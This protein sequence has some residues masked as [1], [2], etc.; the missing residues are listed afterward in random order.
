M[1]LTIAQAAGQA[2]A[3]RG[4]TWA[5]CMPETLSV[6]CDL[7][8]PLPPASEMRLTV[9]PHVAVREPRQR[10]TGPAGWKALT[11]FH[12]VFNRRT[13]MASYVPA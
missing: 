7:R 10:G 3:R 12:E 6:S 1:R 9:R 4:L 11:D 8:D 13:S 5:L 2:D